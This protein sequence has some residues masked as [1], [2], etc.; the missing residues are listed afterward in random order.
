MEVITS[1]RMKEME[2]LRN[3]YNVLSDSLGGRDHL[4]DLGQMGG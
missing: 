2:E 4:A 3:A 1:S